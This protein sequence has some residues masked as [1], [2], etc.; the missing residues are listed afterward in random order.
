MPELLFSDRQTLAK[1]TLA[2]MQPVSFPARDGLT[3]HG[4]LT[5]PVGLEAKNLPMV[6][7]VHGGPWGRDVW[8]MDPLAQLLA[9]RGYAVLQVNFRGSAGYGKAFL[10]AGD[11]EWAGKMHDDLLDA[12][13]WA[14]QQGYADPQKVACDYPA[15]ELDKIVSK[16]FADTG[17]KAF[18]LVKNFQWSNADQNSVSNDI[19]N[20]GMSPDEAAKKWVEANPDKWKAWLPK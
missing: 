15:Y 9:N 8:G 17:G 6:L 16:K 5:L 12:K 10:N 2:R 14:V 13:A 20:N 3:L 7:L 18:E 11:R 19:T 4:Y 1:Y